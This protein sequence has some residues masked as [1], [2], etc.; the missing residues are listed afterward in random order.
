M[1]LS[2]L[3]PIHHW[4]VLA[5]GVSTLQPTMQK[6]SQAVLVPQWIHNPFPRAMAGRSSS[7]ESHISTAAGQRGLDSVEQQE[8]IVSNEQRGRVLNWTVNVRRFIT[9]GKRRGE[10]IRACP[11][12]NAGIGVVQRTPFPCSCSV[13]GKSTVLDSISHRLP[14][15]KQGQSAIIVIP[16]SLPISKIMLFIPSQLNLLINS[17]GFCFSQPFF[18]DQ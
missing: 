9:H 7:A 10:D 1:Q 8:W 17:S 15:V 16:M 5:R 2:I 14:S 4:T 11:G 3:A 13:Q 6:R 12:L 18:P